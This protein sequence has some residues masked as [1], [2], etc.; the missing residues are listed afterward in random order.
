M[1]VMIADGTK[2]GCR[3]VENL[4]SGAQGIAV[5]GSADSAEALLKALD[6]FP[7]D[8]L[9]LDIEIGGKGGIGLL[10]R[11]L[12]EH[13]SLKVIVLTNAVGRTY[14]TQCRDAGALCFLDKSTEFHKTGTAIA[15]L[16][17]SPPARPAIT[18]SMEGK[19]S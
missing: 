12:R 13:P 15:G 11:I 10:R 5:V 3:R 19:L 1:N 2:V 8:A 14:R 18:T 7:V 17:R 4:I 6:L 9:V 16:L